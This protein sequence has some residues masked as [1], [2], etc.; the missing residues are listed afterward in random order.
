MG[1][2]SSYHSWFQIIWFLAVLGQERFQWFTLGLGLVTLGYAAYSSRDDIGRILALGV[3]GIA[4]R[5]L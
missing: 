4:L 3:G 2:Y 1:P 5:F